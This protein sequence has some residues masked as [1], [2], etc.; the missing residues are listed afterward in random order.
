MS[1]GNEV[2]MLSGW[3]RL[4]RPGREVFSEDLERLSQGAVLSRGLGRA[5]GDAALPPPGTIDVAT[6][7][8]ADRI[9]AFDEQTGVLR[10]EA[11]LSLRALN[12]LLIN[13]GWFT[14]VTPGTMFVTLGG[15]VAADVHGKNHHSA[16]C[17]GSHVRAIKIRVADGRVMECSPEQESEL[18]WA[19]VGGM[20]LTGHILEVEVTMARIPSP[21]IAGES[22]RIANLDEFVDQLKESGKTYPATA[23]WIDC[24]SRGSSMGR[25]ILFR[26]DWAKPDQAP[27]QPPKPH[28]SITVP[29]ELPSGVLNKL[30]ARAFNEVVYR[31]HVSKHHKGFESWEKFYYPLDKVLHWNRVYGRRGFTQFQCVLPE[32]AGRAAVRRFLT[33]LTSRGDASFLCVIKDCGAEGKGMLSFPMSGTSIALD[34]PVHSGTQELIDTL[35]KAV[36]DEGGRIYLAKDAFTRGE[37][38]RRM[39]PRVERFL[40]VRRKWDP[41]LTLRSAQ[42]VRIFGDPA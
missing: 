34:F 15:M 14:P 32:A 8:L 38:F 30:S 40:E 35:N 26:G 18:F 19:T 33:L 22:I 2:P 37:D 13:R 24:I 9:L 12:F 21:W 6:T 36:M 1:K 25:G 7:V 20:G 10:A 16:G 23:G 28:R 31:S 42:S 41:N 5:Y 39:D 29:F 27:K 11:G 3:G 4:L 17:F